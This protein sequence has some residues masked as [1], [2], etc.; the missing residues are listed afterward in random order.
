[1]K[2]ARMLFEATTL[3]EFENLA[4]AVRERLSVVDDRVL[5]E[6]G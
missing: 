3:S 6:L 4:T 2:F 1:M 5:A